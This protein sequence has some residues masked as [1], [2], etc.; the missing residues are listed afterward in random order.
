MTH[1]NGLILN[2]LILL[3]NHKSYTKSIVRM[4]A[5]EKLFEIK[6]NK[7]STYLQFLYFLLLL[8]KGN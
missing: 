4:W 1:K 3:Q 7:M 6:I 2:Q 5:K 8:T